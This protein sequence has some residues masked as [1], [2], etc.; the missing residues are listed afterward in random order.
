MAN[1]L[2]EQIGRR[3]VVH[4]DVEA[5]VVVD[6]TV[7][8]SFYLVLDLQIGR[9]PH[10]LAPGVGDLTDDGGSSLDIATSDDNACALLR[11]SSC[12]RSADARC[13]SGHDGDLG[14]EAPHRAPRSICTRRLVSA[15][16]AIQE[17]HV[18][19]F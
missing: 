14:L 16:V 18:N 13:R 10:C 5:A 19:G 15:T 8:E 3:G 7:D 2:K 17:S 6:R 11:Q 9:Q 12:R 4:D 1:A